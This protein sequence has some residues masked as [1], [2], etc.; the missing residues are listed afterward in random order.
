MLS[1]ETSIVQTVHANRSLKLNAGSVFEDIVGGSGNDTLTGNSLVNTLTSN[2]GNDKLTGGSGNDSLV[3]GSG[4]DTYVFATATTAEADTVTEAVTA[5][6]DTL[7]FSSLTTDVILSLETTAVQTVHANRTLK[8]NTTD[9]FENIVGGSG[10]DSLTGNSLPNTLTGNAGNDT[11]T[12]GGG[13]DSLVGGSGDDNY[14]FRTATTVEADTVAEAANAGTDRLSFSSLTTD[15]MLSLETSIVQT[16]HAN[17]SLKLNA[18]SVFED[19][20]GGSGNDTLTGNLLANT[21]TGNAGKDTLIGVSGDDSLVG[22]LGDDTY[23]FRTATTAEADTVTEAESAGTDTLWF[24]SLTTDV[25]LS[26]ETTAV[27][28]VHANRTLKLNTTDAFENIVGGTGNDTLTGNSLA[29]IL[30]GNAGGD[31]LSGG[32]GRDILIGGLGLDT[33][34]GGEDE[35]ILIAGRTTSDAVFS[36]LNLLLE[37]WVSVNSYTTRISNLR[38]S[39]G[40]PAVSLKAKVNVLND[41]GEDDSLVGGNGTDWY[42]R[43]LDDVVTG[44]VTGEIMDI[45]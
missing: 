12:G 6:T 7:W 1:L 11:L 45:L 38:A 42:F 31:T 15:V 24:S 25:I 10:N 33:L 29:N 37:E 27:Q 3:G 28:T 41:A 32:G 34:T 4:D 16:V 20:V 9:A 39:V 44:L 8:L 5:G 30:V 13:N 26:L 19:I 2:A 40:A 21:L 22:G 18:G 17:R 23:V 14:V 36:K 35:D 43:A